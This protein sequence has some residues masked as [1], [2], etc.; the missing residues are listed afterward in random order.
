[1]GYQTILFDLD[2]TLTDPKLGITTAAATALRH[3]GIHEGPENLTKMIGPPLHGAFQ[4]FYGFTPEQ[5]DEAVRQFRLYYNDRG[6][7]EN[8]PY[9]GIREMLQ[10]LRQ[11]G[12]TLIVATS[13]PEATAVRVL[14]YFDMAACFDL[15]CGAPP[16]PPEASKKACVIRNALSRMNITSLDGV[17]MVGDRRHDIEGAHEV[18]IPAIGVLYGY[19]S[20][21]ELQSCGADTITETV[22]SLSALLL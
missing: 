3:F 12:K 5:A 9:P 22:Q 6:W 15:I 11:A 10:Q 7:A 19:G 8:V 17:V 13:K 20:L 21:N 16:A 2:G 18:G 1:M 4:E 14:E